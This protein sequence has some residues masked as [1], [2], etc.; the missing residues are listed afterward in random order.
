[1]PE[2]TPPQFS[3]ATI[4]KEE[5]N[6][7]GNKTAALNP[8]SNKR[9]QTQAPMERTNSEA[10]EGDRKYLDHKDTQIW[11]LKRCCLKGLEETTD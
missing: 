7:N 10:K 3:R 9:E 1:M 5:A 11:I 8:E 6:K 4:A 2:T